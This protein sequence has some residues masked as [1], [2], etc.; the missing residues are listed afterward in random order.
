MD[1]LTPEHRS[2]NM[3][4]IKSRDT[5]PE[6]Q[7]RQLLHKLGFRFRLDSGNRLFGKP[8]IVLPKY[9]TVVFMHGCFWHRHKGCR[10]CYTP[11]SRHAF[12]HKKFEANRARDEKVRRMLRR[13]GWKVCVVWE[14]QLSRTNY[15]ANRLSKIRY[16]NGKQ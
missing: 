13:L 9:R 10:Y 6:I 8:D 4:R 3:S 15:L 12:W 1:A 5:K 2:W 7:L 16:N 11:K 14:C